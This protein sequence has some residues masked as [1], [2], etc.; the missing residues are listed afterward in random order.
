LCYEHQIP[1]GMTGTFK[2]QLAQHGMPEKLDEVLHETAVVRRELGYPGMATPFS[3]LVGTLAVLNVVTGERYSVIPDE[4]IQYAAGYY[5]EPVAPIEPDILDKI[6]SA[7]RAKEIARREPPQPSL[8]DLRRELGR[9]LSDDELI[10]RALV[11]QSHIEEMHAA[12]PVRRDYLGL[13]SP[14]ITQVEELM[15]SMTNSYVQFTNEK[16]SVT[17]RRHS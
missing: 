10:L 17:L 9:H 1:G 2:N 7:P 3:Q 6:M 14:E 12:G 5:G 8:E 15:R 16:M 13:S 11:P 4:V